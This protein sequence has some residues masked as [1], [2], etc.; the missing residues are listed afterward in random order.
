MPITI[1]KDQSLPETVRFTWIQLRCLAWGRS[2]T[3][4]LSI[5]QIGKIL[6][7]KQSAVYKHMAMLRDQGAL[8]WRPAGCGTLI[9]SF[10]D[11]LQE[12]SSGGVF[13]KNSKRLG[14][15]QS[16]ETNSINLEKFSKFTESPFNVFVNN[17]YQKEEKLKNAQV[18]KSG[19]H[20]SQ[21]TPFDKCGVDAINSKELDTVQSPKATPFHKNGNN[22]RTHKCVSL[23]KT[24]TNLTPNQLQRKLMAAKVTDLDLWRASLEHWLSHGWNPRNV[25]GMLNLYKQG[26][27]DS[28]HFCHPKKEQPE[29]V[30]EDFS[31]QRE[32]DRLRVRK[33]IEDARARKAAEQNVTNNAQL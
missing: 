14:S 22:A 23:Y 24:L 21:T 9:V 29:E 5:Q 27:P 20:I 30:I 3:P 17:R 31:E 26:G 15:A 33:L 12:N 32:R 8:R 11:H 1:I 13:E 10:P 2:E 19:K 7:K 4:E 6:G 18:Q 28:C 16:P 25:L